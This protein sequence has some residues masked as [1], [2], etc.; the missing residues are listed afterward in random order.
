MGKNVVSNFQK[1][2]CSLTKCWL[3]GRVEGSKRVF[4]LLFAK[5]FQNIYVM[6]FYN[7]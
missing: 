4:Y 3:G 7:Y 1:E 2:E 6:W 5:E